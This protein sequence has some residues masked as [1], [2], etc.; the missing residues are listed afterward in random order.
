[1]EDFE[2]GSTF[3]AAARDESTGAALTDGFDARDALRFA[4]AHLPTFEQPG[5]PSDEQVEAFVAA[6]LCDDV[7]VVFD[8]VEWRD[9]GHVLLETSGAMG[10]AD[11][12][13][14][15]RLLTMLVRQDRF[16]AGTL[17]H[18]VE[19]GWIHAVLH[20]MHAIGS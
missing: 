11:L 5:G 4:R 7:M 2:G 10:R 14:L 9:Q 18:A 12:D 19:Q 13:D 3:G 1:M 6:L 17:S 8:W 15:R 16:A 20:R